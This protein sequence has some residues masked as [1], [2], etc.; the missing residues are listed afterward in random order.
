MVKNLEKLHHVICERPLC[1]HP[2]F[3]TVSVFFLIQVVQLSMEIN[4]LQTNGSKYYHSLKNI[5]AGEM[6]II[7][8]LQI[9]QISPRNPLEIIKL[10]LLFEPMEKLK[11]IL[12]NLL[13]HTHAST[14]VL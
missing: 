14:T 5:H 4:G 6:K 3:P 11:P 10:T 7:L 13:S 8:L 1:M 2:F 9:N 12:C